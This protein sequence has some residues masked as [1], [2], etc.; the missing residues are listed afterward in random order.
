MGSV[1]CYQ[2]NITIKK[3]YKRAFNK[4]ISE[5]KIVEM[6]GGLKNAVYLIED[7]DGK[8]VLK[9]ASNNDNSMIYVDRNIFWWEI[10]MLNKMEK[11]DFPSPRVLFYDDT[12]EICNNPYAFMTYID[13]DNLLTAKKT[14]KIEELRKIEYQIGQLSYKIAQIDINDYFLPSYSNK[15]FKTNYDFILFLF[16]KLLENGKEHNSSI[17]IKEYSSIMEILNKFR[18]ELNDNISIKLCHTDIWDGNIL[19]KNNNV[20]GI[21][22]FSDLYV[23][24]ELFTFYFHTIDG[25]TSKY[26][27]KGYNNK[28]LQYNEKIRI[29]IYR[30]YV[31]LKMII[32][33]KLKNYGE[34]EWMSNNLNKIMKKLKKTVKM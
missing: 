30:M 4:E 16:E 10:E 6:S 31:I 19:I 28:K 34:F 33:S 17:A 24:D 5:I 2:D 11:I 7:N 9:I 18:V 27:L 25:K 12:L 26:F 23:C 22:D 32:D 21:V 14:L 8:Y 3:M 13:G 29:D 15:K 20:V 1:K